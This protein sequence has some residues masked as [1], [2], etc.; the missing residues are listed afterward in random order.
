MRRCKSGRDLQKRTE[1]RTRL[2]KDKEHNC[3]PLCERGIKRC[4]QNE[5]TDRGVKGHLLSCDIN[6]NP[7]RFSSVHGCCSLQKETR[8]RTTHTRLLAESRDPAPTLKNRTNPGRN[9]E[10][11]GNNTDMHDERDD[12]IND[13]DRRKTENLPHVTGRE[14]R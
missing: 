9:L 10:N 11:T 12:R 1:T 14:K 7:G 3:R 8:K 4:R 5:E 2:E 13:K 6:L